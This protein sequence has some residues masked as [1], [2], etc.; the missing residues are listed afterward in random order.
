MCRRD[1]TTARPSASIRASL[2]RLLL[3]NHISCLSRTSV[4]ILQALSL[5]LVLLRCLRNGKVPRCTEH[6]CDSRHVNGWLR[7]RNYTEAR[8]PADCCSSENLLLNL[9]FS[10]ASDQ[11]VELFQRCTITLIFILTAPLLWGALCGSSASCV[12]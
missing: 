5:C 7:D 6:P 8:N 11:Y 10:P 12:K 9:V 4:S 1:P 2:C 3:L